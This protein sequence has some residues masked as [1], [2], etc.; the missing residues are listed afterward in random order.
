MDQ[1]SED[2]PSSGQVYW[3]PSLPQRG[4]ALVRRMNGSLPA[5]DGPDQA[6]SNC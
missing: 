4:C 2:E 3:A 1:S 5:Q 6:A